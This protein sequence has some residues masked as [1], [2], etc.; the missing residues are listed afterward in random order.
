MKNLL[1]PLFIS[2]ILSTTQQAQTY[3]RGLQTTQTSLTPAPKP[4]SERKLVFSPYVNV[5]QDFSARSV[6]EEASVD[7][8]VDN[9]MLGP[10]QNSPVPA[11]GLGGMTPPSLGLTHQPFNYM[12]GSAMAHPMNPMGGMAGMAGMPG[13]G[14]MGLMGQGGIGTPNPN[15]QSLSQNASNETGHY[16]D[17]HDFNEIGDDV[18]LN[19]DYDITRKLK[20]FD[21]PLNPSDGIISQCN[22]TQQQ[23]IQISN[24]IMKKQNKII[25]KE[26]M[27][28]L[29][30]SKY[31]I[32]T[33]EIKLVRV[34]R[35]KIYGL[36]NQYSSITEDKLDV[37]PMDQE[38]NV[39]HL[40]NM[41]HF[42][43]LETVVE[44]DMHERYGD[45]DNEFGPVE[46]NW[47]DGVI[48]VNAMRR[49]NK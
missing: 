35:K 18:K 11:F 36:M 29:L 27:K 31:L 28:Y 46:A 30:K 16:N 37:V 32:A 19:E 10:F 12:Y 15:P 21:D 49:R 5:A 34:L 41:D 2:L 47:D 23:A 3:P 20:L 40:D 1:F 39:D 9:A 17:L 4:Q 24:A 13:M 22:D 7:Q 42:D 43:H 33:T 45:H 38:G 25:Y 6:G 8:P 44:E 14:M 48:D 26:I